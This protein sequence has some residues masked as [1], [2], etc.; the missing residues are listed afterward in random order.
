MCPLLNTAK[1]HPVLDGTRT[2]GKDQ[3]QMAVSPRAVLGSQKFPGRVSTNSLELFWYPQHL[4]KQLIHYSL[5]CCSMSCPRLPD[6]CATCRE[7]WFTAHLCHLHDGQTTLAAPVVGTAMNFYGNFP[8]SVTD[9]PGEQGLLKGAIKADTDEA[10]SPQE[11]EQ[12][13][14]SWVNAHVQIQD[15]SAHRR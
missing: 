2:A 8:G 12:A 14:R 1:I 15:S 13:V 10:D 9:P 7:K 6:L 5:P 4:R 3:P 11:T